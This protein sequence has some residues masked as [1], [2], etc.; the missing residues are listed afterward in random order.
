MI[1]LRLIA[2]VIIAIASAAFLEADVLTFKNDNVIN[3]WNFH[4]QATWTYQENPNF[5]SAYQGLNSFNS[6]A[7][8]E[9]T[10]S[11]SAFLDLEV[12]KDLELIY[13]P[14][15]F[16]GYGLSHSLGIAG[17]P[18]G[19]A[20]KSGFA[21]LHYNTSRL[22]MRHTIGLGG[23]KEK[24]EDDINQ[25]PGE[26]DVNRI[27]L[28]GGLFSASDFFDDNTYSHDTRSQFM[29]WSLW[30]SGAWDYPANIVGFTAGVVVEWYISN[31]TLRYG[32]FMDSAESN[33]AH[34]DT[35]LGKAHAQ[36]I[37]YDR[38]Y[39]ID[40]LSGTIRVMAFLNDAN[41]GLYSTA[42]KQIYPSNIILTRSYRSK[43]GAAISLDQQLSDSVGFF[44]RISWNDGKE[45]DWA[46]TEIDQSIAAGLSDTGKFWNRPADVVGIAG[47][48][49]MISDAHQKYLNNGGLGLILGDGKLNYGSEDIIE[50]YYNC[51]L[52]GYLSVSLDYQYIKNPGYN[53]SRG[54]VPVYSLRIHTQF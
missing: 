7:D 51:K 15:L 2:A 29:N 50:T 54:P 17:F 9:Y 4:D 14:E 18:N 46:F 36:V 20:V 19:E 21:N 34:L 40:K 3:K 45:E 16:Q 48:K 30:E 25:L 42:D 26:R 23:D 37:Q 47:V 12:F 31:A 28:S 38:H 53:V 8:Q 6:K 41:M 39:F 32:V 52:T 35:H 22:F 1:N 10:L 24:V 5:L 13:N 33:G 49:N 27:V 44:N 11:I 43:T